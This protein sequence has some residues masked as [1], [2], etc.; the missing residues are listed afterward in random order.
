MSS[1]L[2][3]YDDKA[4]EAAKSYLKEGNIDIDALNKENGVIIIGKNRVFNAKTKRNFYGP[5]IDLN[6]G[7]EIL[8]QPDE[9]SKGKEKIEFGQGVVNKVKVLAVLEDDPFTFRGNE[10]GLKIIASKATAEKLASSNINPVGLNI[11]LKDTKLENEAKKDIENIIRGSNN[12]RLMNIIDQNRSTRG[13]ILMVKI[14]LYGFVVV[15]SLIGGVNIINTLTTNIILRRREFASLKSIGLTQKGLRKMITLEGILYGIMGSV[16]GAAL[17]SLI[18]Y[19]LYM[20]VNDV[21]ELSFKFPWDS[22]AAA[23]A[24]AMLIGYISV[25]API[26]RMKKDNLIEAVREDF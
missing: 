25:L 2:V 24:G 1:S 26:R 4:L 18:S 7:D 14:L 21:R 8:L 3:V 20:G 10:A 15:V 23:A 6:A 5:I 19:I 12:I 11:R 17:G 9:E 13:V 16:Y 22:I